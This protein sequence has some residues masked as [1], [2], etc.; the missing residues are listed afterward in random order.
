MFPLASHVVPASFEWLGSHGVRIGVILV[1]AVG[2]SVAARLAVRRMHH[3]LAGTVDATLA[4]SLRRVATLTQTLSSAIRVVVWTFALLLALGELGFQLGPLLA[5]AGIAGVALGFGAQSLVRDFLSGFF[6]LLEDQY[7]VGDLV[8]LSAP[9]WKVEGRVESLTL[10]SSTIRA[11]DG[12]LHA[13]ANGVIQVVGNRS[14][15]Y[16]RAIVDVQLAYHQDV[17]EAR[18]VLEDL[19][20]G[21]GDELGS[22]LQEEPR[23]LGLET[24]EGSAVVLR[25]V[26][27]TRPSRRD[28]VER[29]LRRRIKQRFDER[30]VVTPGTAELDRVQ[31]PA[32]AAR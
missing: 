3:R 25:V 13:V 31:E 23:V 8:E 20:R 10:R 28:E 4:T 30:G 27:D 17:E 14:R 1:V 22:S 18:S 12:T 9:G 26:A 5:G 32:S 7:G 29:E 6:I 21:L 11:F 2:V 24:V 19:F 16:A 15:G